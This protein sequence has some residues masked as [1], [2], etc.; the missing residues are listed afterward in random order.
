MAPGTALAYL[1]IMSSTVA[2]IGFTDPSSLASIVREKGEPVHELSST[3]LWVDS[4]GA[5]LFLDRNAQYARPG[6]STPVRTPYRGITPMENG[7][8]QV[9][10]TDVS[11][12]EL[13]PFTV[14]PN[15]RYTVGWAPV[16]RVALVAM[17]IDTEFFPT[18]EDFFDSPRSALPGFEGEPPAEVKQ[19][20]LAWPPTMEIETFLPS[21]NADDALA[22]LSGTV[23]FAEVQKNSLTGHEFLVSR[24][25]TVCGEVDLCTPLPLEGAP[26]PGS[27]VVG[28]VELLAG[29]PPFGVADTSSYQAPDERVGPTFRDEEPEIP[30]DLPPAD[31]DLPEGL[32]LGEDG[33][34]RTDEEHRAWKGGDTEAG[35]RP[36][37]GV[38][39]DTRDPA[40]PED[41][42]DARREVP[43]FEVDPEAPETVEGQNTSSAPP[44][45]DA[46]AGP[47]SGFSESHDDSASEG[48]TDASS[49]DLPRPG[50][51]RREWRA[52][53]GR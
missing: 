30:S 50:E 53:T 14:V 8:A 38:S 27:V 43:E 45:T 22:T 39:R 42:F 7:L 9:V 19:F 26:T 3:N 49:D 34:V 44:P 10:F 24:I 16:G 5:T 20:G 46:P 48:E 36:P 32:V 12:F 2:C 52:R 11:G 47:E 35:S 18:A 28:Q 17:G 51:T 15:N 37:A 31:E 13:D 1:W 40:S 29:F 4:S 33:V 21:D 23:Q 25:A 41:E 6:F